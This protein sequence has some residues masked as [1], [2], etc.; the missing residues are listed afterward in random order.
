MLLAQ[1]FRG[2]ER[3]FDG[4]VHAGETVQFPGGTL[5]LAPDV[6]LWVD[7]LATRDPWLPLAIAGLALIVLGAA[8]RAGIAV[9]GTARRQANLRSP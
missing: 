8:L 6:L 9:A 4:R 2:R 3:V 1:V 7:L 5:E